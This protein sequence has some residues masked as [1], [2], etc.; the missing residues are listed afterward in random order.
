[1][2]KQD[3]KQDNELIGQA[4]E[5]IQ[6]SSKITLLT[7]LKP[8]GDGIAACIALELILIR[9]GKMVETV[10]PT[11][12]ELE[13]QRRPQKVLINEHV[14]S[15][16]LLIALDTANYERLYYPKDFEEIPLINIDH[17]VSNTISGTHNFVD[18]DTSSTCEVLFNLVKSWNEK[19]IDKEIAENLLFGLLYDSRMFHTQSTHSTTLRIAADL[20]DHGANLFQLK[21]ELLAH[22][23]PKIFKLWELLLG[24]I[25]VSSSGLA[26]WSYI[27]QEDLKGLG[28]ELSS[29]VGFNDFLADISGIDVT[30]LFY[31]TGEGDTKVSLRS[32]EYDVNE[33]A[34]KFGGGGHKNAAG[35]RNK[36]PLRELMEEM[37]AEL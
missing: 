1:M 37:V 9:L 12:P 26:A 32:K 31:E 21:L 14:Q 22:K 5:L 28:L 35:I 17:H 19:L 3:K 34:A 2:S 33:L 16:D 11:P 10:Y 15:P 7:H 30:L 13:L 24:R 23:S 4:W 18:P 20:M 36:K 6:K 25:E 29:L 8:D 27:T